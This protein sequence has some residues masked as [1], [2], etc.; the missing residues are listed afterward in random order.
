MRPFHLERDISGVRARIS[1]C[2]VPMDCK[3]QAASNYVCLAASCDRLPGAV[4]QADGD[5]QTQVGANLVQGPL[6][7]PRHGLVVMSVDI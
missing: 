3:F 6:W 1:T 7:R 5:H 4:L 2:L